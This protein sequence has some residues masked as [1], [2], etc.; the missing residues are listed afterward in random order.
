[1]KVPHTHGIGKEKRSVGAKEKPASNTKIKLVARLVAGSVDIVN[2]KSYGKVKERGGR[3]REMLY[4][5]D[6]LR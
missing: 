1:M 2:S 6:A 4:G 3:G 5:R